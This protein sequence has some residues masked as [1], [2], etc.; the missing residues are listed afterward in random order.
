MGAATS[1]ARTSSFVPCAVMLWKHLPPT[2]EPVKKSVLP[3]RSKH[4]VI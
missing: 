3:R 4:A 2:R 1:P